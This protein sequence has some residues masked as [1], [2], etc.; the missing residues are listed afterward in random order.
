MYKTCLTVAAALLSCSMLAQAESNPVRSMSFNTN[1]V[2]DYHVTATNPQMVTLTNLT[3]KRFYTLSCYPSIPTIY[4]DDVF[5]TV[6]SGSK[7]ITTSF[8]GP[9]GETVA[10]YNLIPYEHQYKK[11]AI[12]YK[13]ETD[14]LFSQ[15]GYCKFS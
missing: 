8:G 9:Y 1:A 6:W 2:I 7:T 15:T 11:Y 4:S 3:A 13:L 5:L 10:L 12:E 14:S